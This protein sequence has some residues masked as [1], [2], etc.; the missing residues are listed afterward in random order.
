MTKKLVDYSALTKFIRKN[1]C[2]VI[3]DTVLFC[4]YCDET[5][6]Y[7]PD[8]GTNK[9]KRHLFSKKHIETVSQSKIQT[10]LQF[11]KIN[12]DENRIFHIELA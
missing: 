11:E 7:K 1:D 8:H 9:L 6:E 10:R 2:S 4:K 12:S 5:K 3:E